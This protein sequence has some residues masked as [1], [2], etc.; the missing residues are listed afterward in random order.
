MNS[1]NTYIPPI[2]GGFPFSQAHNCLL[3]C[4]QPDLRV[5]F[6]PIKKNEKYNILTQISATA[7]LKSGKLYRRTKDMGFVATTKQATKTHETTVLFVYDKNSSL[8]F[9]IDTGANISIIPRKHACYRT[10]EQMGLLYAANGSSITTYGHTLQTV[11]FSLGK[12][13]SWELT[14]ANV[15]YPILI[16]GLLKHFHLVVNLHG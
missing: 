16:A 11:D 8:H 1:Y 15:K 14:T 3:T 7:P 12:A 9:L 4:D 6:S 2:L 5:K 13:Y 10:C